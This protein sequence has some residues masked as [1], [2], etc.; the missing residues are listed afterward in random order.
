[1]HHLIRSTTI[2]TWSASFPG[3]SVSLPVGVITHPTSPPLILGIKLSLGI[4]GLSQAFGHV[5]QPD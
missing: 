5:R 2:G 3:P 4:T 1:M